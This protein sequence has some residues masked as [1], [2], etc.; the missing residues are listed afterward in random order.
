MIWKYSRVYASFEL[1][2]ASLINRT[3]PRETIE[4]RELPLGT[5]REH[6]DSR[7]GMFFH[8]HRFRHL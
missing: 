2:R 4:N 7:A 5:I 8:T 6:E 1:P 3:R